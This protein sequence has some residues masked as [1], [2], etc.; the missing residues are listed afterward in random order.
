MKSFFCMLALLATP[1]FASAV[2]SITCVPSFDPD[3]KVQ[4]RFSSNIDP[5][6]P[7]VGTYTSSAVLK[8]TQKNSRQA[9]EVTV[10]TSPESRGTNDLRGDAEGVYLKLYPQTENGQFTHYTGQLFVNDLNV[11]AYFKFINEG[12]EPGLV[13]N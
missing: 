13:C 4:V 5:L 8:V 9:Y 1:A 6:N 2:T 11:R 3:F 7:F 12:N 10:R